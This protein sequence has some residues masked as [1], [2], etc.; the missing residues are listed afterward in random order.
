VLAFI[1]RE[2]DA[3]VMIPLQQPSG[4]AGSLVET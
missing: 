2:K 1:I 3:A 4:G